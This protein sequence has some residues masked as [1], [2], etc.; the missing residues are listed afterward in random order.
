MWTEL[1]SM[2][3]YLRT[4]DVDASRA[5][6]YARAAEQETQRRLAGTRVGAEARAAEHVC[7]C[8]VSYTHLRAHET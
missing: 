8:A 7:L 4:N 6:S 2:W 3:V 1:M 5:R